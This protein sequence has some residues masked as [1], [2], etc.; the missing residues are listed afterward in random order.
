MCMIE[1]EQRMCKNNVFNLIRQHIVFT[2]LDHMKRPRN[3]CVFSSVF[4]KITLEY[5]RNKYICLH[6]ALY[7]GVIIFIISIVCLIGQTMPNNYTM[8]TSQHFV[9]YCVC[10]ANSQIHCRIRHTT[11]STDLLHSN[12]YSTCSAN[13]IAPIYQCNKCPYPIARGPTVDL[14]I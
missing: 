5:N 9:L 10:G 3:W 14:L 7:F 8:A 1:T 13:T 4:Y 12:L 2:C 11:Q 6:E